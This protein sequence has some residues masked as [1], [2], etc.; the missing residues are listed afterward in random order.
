MCL[1]TLHTLPYLISTARSGGLK[2]NEGLRLEGGH[3]AGKH[4]DWPSILE[5][6]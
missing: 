5:S 4:G 1:S 3:A 6:V 2:E